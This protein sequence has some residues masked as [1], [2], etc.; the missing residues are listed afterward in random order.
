M[1]IETSQ[2]IRPI[3][4]RLGDEKQTYDFKHA[5][6]HGVENKDDGKLMSLICGYTDINDFIMVYTNILVECY[7]FLEENY[8]DGEDFNVLNVLKNYTHDIFE[9]LE[10]GDFKDSE[11]VVS[12][13]L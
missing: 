4:V 5:I 12:E 8:E 10:R 11:E 1:Q 3:H 6:I 9:G 7:H 2:E 13:T